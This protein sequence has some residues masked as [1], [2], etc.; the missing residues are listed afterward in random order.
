[1]RGDLNDPAAYTAVLKKV[2]EREKA[3]PAPSGRGRLVYL[4]IPPSLYVP[5]I[6]HLAQSGLAPRV[7]DAAD[8]HWVRVIVEKPFGRSRKTAAELNRA[9]SESLSE[10]QVYRIDHYLGK[11]TVQNILVLR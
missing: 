2:E 8:P 7:R 5:V 4:A 10:H 3:G 11:E 9:V 6:G 1:V